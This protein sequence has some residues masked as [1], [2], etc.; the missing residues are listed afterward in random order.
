MFARELLPVLGPGAANALVGSVSATATAA[1]TTQATATAISTSVT[2]CSTATEGQG[3]IL[4]ASMQSGDSSDVCNATTVDIYIYP[5]V[6]G[7]LNGGTANIPMML[8]ANSARYFIC[9][10]G[11]NWIVNR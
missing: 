5:P 2:V 4:P 10:D 11:T 7:K 9:I 3:F 6:G 8:A 1:G